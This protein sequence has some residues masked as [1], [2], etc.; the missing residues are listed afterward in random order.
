[1][2]FDDAI[3]KIANITDLRRVARAHVVDHKQLS[4]EELAD[5]IIKIKPQYVDRGTLDQGL[6]QVL[7]L[8]PREDIR[9]LAYVFL[10][11]VLLQ[12][13]DTQLR[14]EETDEK[15]IGFEQR[16]VDRSNETDLAELACGDKSSTRF[17]DLELYKFV[18]EV[19]WANL[20]TVS[21]DEANLL[22]KLRDRLRINETDHR[23]LEAHLKKY[24]RANNETHT[25]SDVAEVRKRFQELGILIPVRDEDGTDRDVIAEETAAVLR[26][27]L[28]VTL[29]RDAY[30][31]L[32]DHKLLR[33]KS[34]Y[35]EILDAAK[36]PY[37]RYD[38]LDKLRER[39]LENVPADRAIA[40]SSPR[41][42]LNKEELTELCKDL[43]LPI[44]GS[45]QE[46]VER[47]LQHYAE[48]RPRDPVPPDER[49]LWF[50]HYEAL[51]FR[52]R[53][54]LYK[55]HVIEKDL[56]IEH[57]FED[58]TRYLF[59]KL[60]GHTP[61]KQAGSNHS[62]GLLSLKSSYLMW[63][64]KSKEK[65]GLVSLKA[66]LPQFHQ[67]MDA[68]EKSVPVFVVIAPGFTDDSEVEV[69]RYKGE[70]FDRNI[71]LITAGELKALALEWASTENKNREQPFN[72]GLFAMSGRYD[73]KR[74]GKLY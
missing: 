12:Q 32:L 39:V 73:R 64:N 18:L 34:H 31:E 35:V 19:A 4:N 33:K 53:D 69:T 25:R 70:H 50:E 52:D 10:V 16:I 62:D 29:R 17:R 58:A 11:D 8:E 60:L 2:K 66:H 9:A 37:G 45:V 38:T 28:G 3:R 57:K 13:Y 21:P 65:P 20:D 47:V 24:P 30:F 48:L 49:V 56:E 40:S 22:H 54:T 14:E 51:A 42:G 43:N 1:M 27:I 26:D 44:S 74:L 63:D 72:L 5:A 6:R 61:L 46:L 7:H 71:L 68:S 59:D 55:Q 23:I 67:Y 41:F 36:V 15:V